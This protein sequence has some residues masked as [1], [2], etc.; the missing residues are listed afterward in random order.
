MFGGARTVHQRLAG[1][2]HRRFGDHVVGKPCEVYLPPFD[3][4]FADDDLDL[5]DIDSVVQPD[6]TVLCEP[7]RF[8]ETGYRGTPSLIVEILSP[9]TSRKDLH[10]KF[11]LYEEF[12][13]QEYWIVDPFAQTVQVFRPTAPGRY[14][15]GELLERTG[16][17]ASRVF[18]GL[19]VELEA[20][21]QS[22]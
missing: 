3:I 8:I 6:L 4:L 16:T 17:M 12:G 20:L 14:D 1:R 2:L 11:S 19:T 5:D 13:V 10:D 7:G 18:P 22:V 21:F 9:S 15:R